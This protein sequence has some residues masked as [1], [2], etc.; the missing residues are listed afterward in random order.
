MC[1]LRDA[2][3]VGGDLYAATVS[4]FSGSDS[5]IIKN[6]LRTEQYDYKHLNGITS[7]QYHNRRNKYIFTYIILSCFSAEFCLISG[8]RGARIFLLPGGSGRIHQLWQGG[9][10]VRVLYIRH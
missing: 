2:V 4:D 6:Q 1:C 3:S 8:R 5:L 9:L 7:L 10:Q